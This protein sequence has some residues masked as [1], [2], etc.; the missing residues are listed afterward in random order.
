MRVNVEDDLF[1]SRRLSKL[2]RSMKMS[3]HEALGL[4]VLFWRATQDQEIITAPRSRLETIAA[5]EVD[6]DSKLWVD[7]LLAAQL[8][9]QYGEEITIHG[10]APHVERLAQLRSNAKSGGLARQNKKPNDFRAVTEP[11]PSRVGASTEPPLSP[12]SSLLPSPVSIQGSNTNTGSLPSTEIIEASSAEFELRAQLPKQPKAKRVAA[13]KPEP[14]DTAKVRRAFLDG[15]AARLPKAGAYPWG[16]RENAQAERWLRSVPL[17]EA[18]VMVAKFFEWSRPEVVRSGYPFGTGSNC[19]IMKYVELKGDMAHPER[20]AFAAMAQSNENESNRRYESQA[21]M[22]RVDTK[23]M[24]GDENATDVFR[25][26]G[27]SQGQT[28]IGDQAAGRSSQP[29]DERRSGNGVVQG[30][31]PIRRGPDAVA[32]NGGWNG[33]RQD[34]QPS[35]AERADE[36][37]AGCEDVGGSY[38]FDSGGEEEVG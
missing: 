31:G 37:E 16:A 10:N 17:P 25:A 33:G 18:L 15:Y 36:G 27:S 12:P 29:A 8:A 28:A 30:I 9:T 35:Q 4:L 6:A 14:T 22:T 21:Q 19:L 13:A 3:D 26:I 11:S 20:R 23:L 34:A 2:A 32:S 38:S 5:L 7:S 1:T 24:T